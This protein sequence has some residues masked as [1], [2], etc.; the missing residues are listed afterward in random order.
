MIS[1]DALER[2]LTI[3]EIF[4]RAVVL[5]VRRWRIAVVL[6]LA[7]ALPS[8]VLRAIGGGRLPGGH[9]GYWG[10]LLIGVPIVA[11]FSAALVRAYGD[12]GAPAEFGRLLRGAARDYRRALPSYAL[13]TLLFYAGLVLVETVVATVF[14]AGSSAGGVATGVVL[15]ALVGIALLAVSVPLCTVVLLA[16]PTTLLEGVGA[17][18]GL[19]LTFERV[20]SGPFARAWLLGAA[21]LTVWL[22]P[23]ILVSSSVDRAAMVTGWSW[24]RLAE[25]AI[26]VLAGWPYS[27]AA[28]VVAA[29]DLRLRREGADLQ[30]ALEQ[31]PPA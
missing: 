20:R 11:F 6:S 15:A 23:M 14:A 12:P 24:L 31:A 1:F 13:V 2:P 22:G 21:L 3:A 25:P 10:A 19:V 27:G 29:I 5:C 16:Y 26:S 9:A 8:T 28:S 7:V 17:R 18:R 4:D 30:A